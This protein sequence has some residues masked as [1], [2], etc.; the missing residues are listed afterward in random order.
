[1]DSDEFML[2]QYG[3]TG[4][5]DFLGFFLVSLRYGAFDALRLEFVRSSESG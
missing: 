5:K 1:M 3:L 4:E 2:H